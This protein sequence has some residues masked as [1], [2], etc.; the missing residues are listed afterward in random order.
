MRVD[1][2][3]GHVSDGSVSSTKTM[4]FEPSEELLECVEPFIKKRKIVF[5]TNDANKKRVQRIKCDKT[6]DDGNYGEFCDRIEEYRNRSAVPD[7]TED[8]SSLGT[9]EFAFGNR[10]A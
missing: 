4:I 9:L 2:N 3:D 7:G 5:T 8:L 6:H 1:D 10:R